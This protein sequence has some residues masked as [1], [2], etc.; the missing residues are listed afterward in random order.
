MTCTLPYPPS[1]NHYWL[2]SSKGRGYISKEGKAFKAAAMTVLAGTV[3]VPLATAV[4][5][6]LRYYRPR[7]SG[8]ID[9][10]LK[11]VLDCLQGVAYR[12]DSQIAEL[13]VWRF[14]DKVHPRVEV[15]VEECDVALRGE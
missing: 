13:L 3:E 1:Y 7:R 11:Q 8:D 15:D 12:N 4:R 2:S 9:N 6:T 5:L 14:E 10:Y